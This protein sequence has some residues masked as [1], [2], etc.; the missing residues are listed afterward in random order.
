MR[1]RQQLLDARQRAMKRRVEHGDLRDVRER[2]AQ[3]VDRVQAVRLMQ[4]RQRRQ[5]A[6]RIQHGIVD[7]QR[8]RVP[9][10]AVHDAMRDRAQRDVRQLLPDPRRDPGEHGT[11]GIACDQRQR[12]VRFRIEADRHVVAA[13]GRFTFVQRPPLGIAVR[14]VRED[15][16]LHARRTGIDDEERERTHRPVQCDIST[17][18]VIDASTVRVAPPITSSRQRGWP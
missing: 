16:E 15:R 7:D 14:R 6:Q 3:R 12:A 18:I 13:P 17:G 2:V 4:R 11:V 10:A 1:Q 8:L 5:R 9:R